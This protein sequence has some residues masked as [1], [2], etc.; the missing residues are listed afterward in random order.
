MRSSAV[1][2]LG[3]AVWRWGTLYWSRSSCP[4]CLSRSYPSLRKRI[5]VSSTRLTHSAIHVVFLQALCT[6]FVPCFNHY[7]Q[8]HCSLCTVHPVLFYRNRLGQVLKKEVTRMI[9]MNC[10]LVRLEQLDSKKGT[11]GVYRDDPLYLFWQIVSLDEMSII[12][13][14]VSLELSFYCS[15]SQEKIMVGLLL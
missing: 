5:G 2:W 15:I 4:R 10:Y 6:L 7:M 13:E 3:V 9:S 8:L 11:I 14:G 12:M 1:Y